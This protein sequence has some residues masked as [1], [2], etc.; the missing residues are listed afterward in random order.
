MDQ[1]ESEILEKLKRADE[2]QDVRLRDELL[3][4]GIRPM[5]S[6]EALQFLRL[7]LKKAKNVEEK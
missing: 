5:T 2:L 1:Y 7:T 4:K 6:E 3:T